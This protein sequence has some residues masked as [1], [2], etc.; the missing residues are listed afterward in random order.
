MSE[1]GGWWWQLCVFVCELWCVPIY[2]GRFVWHWV[3]D[4]VQPSAVGFCL[5]CLGC[6]CWNRAWS[7]GEHVLVG[8][9]TLT[10]GEQ[11]AVKREREKKGRHKWVNGVEN[12]GG[13][14]NAKFEVPIY[15]QKI[16]PLWHGQ[17]IWGLR[18]TQSPYWRSSSE[19]RLQPRYCLCD[20][21]WTI[22][23]FA[24]ITVIWHDD[25]YWII[26]KLT[27]DVRYISVLTDRGDCVFCVC[28]LISGTQ[29][30]AADC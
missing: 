23:R 21:Y 4:C 6:R 30:K 16:T 2:S 25:A 10:S 19:L 3:P 26:T 12:R 20:G 1:D 13:C 22:P 5:H 18:T 24:E 14:C 8:Y 9:K 27:T 17:E 7:E 28:S 11:F 15:V 29:D